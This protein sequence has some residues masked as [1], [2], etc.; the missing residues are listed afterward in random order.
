MSVHVSD[1]PTLSSTYS[2]CVCVI[3]SRHPTA[4][5]DKHKQKNRIDPRSAP[6]SGGRDQSWSGD[7]SAGLRSASQS[8][9]QS[10]ALFV[11]G[12]TAKPRPPQN[13]EV[14]RVW[15]TVS[16]P[17]RCPPP[18][19]SP[20]LLDT[21]TRWRSGGRRAGLPLVEVCEGA[22]LTAVWSARSVRRWCPETRPASSAARAR[23]ASAPPP[24]PAGPVVV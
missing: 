9:I 13:Q 23:P 14:S 21:P 5:P 3:D 1:S 15:S 20:E 19:S 2:F 22:G 8:F 24:G 12:D 4:A 16:C 18:L 7:I 11:C 6:V 10:A 17:L